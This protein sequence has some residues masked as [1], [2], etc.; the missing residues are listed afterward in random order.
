MR[1]DRYKYVLH[2]PGKM[3]RQEADSDFYE[4]KYLFDLKNDPLERNN[5]IADPAYARVKKLRERLLAFSKDAG[6]IILEIKEI[7]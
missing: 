7:K 4:E 2:A 5:L 3:P 6:E 1:T